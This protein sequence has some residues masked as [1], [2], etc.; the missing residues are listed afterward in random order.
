MKIKFTQLQLDEVCH[1]LSIIR[2]EPDLQ[3]SYDVSQEEAE[4]FYEYFY[5]SKEGEIDL[6][7]EEKYIEILIG[8]IQNSM[9]RMWSNWQDCNDQ[10][11]GASYRSMNL[12]LKKI[13]NI[14]KE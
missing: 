4:N 8:E 3:E 2:D 7:F 11:E 9:E 6:N 10:S 5:N 1:K 14:S 12:L 13:K